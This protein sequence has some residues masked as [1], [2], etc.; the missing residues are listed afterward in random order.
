[1]TI[2]CR[3]VRLIGTVGVVTIAIVILILSTNCQANQTLQVVSDHTRIVDTSTFADD[4]KPGDEVFSVDPAI[5]VGIDYETSK[6][7]LTVEPSKG[8]HRY[9]RVT[10]RD[11]KTGKTTRCGASAALY[12][13]I[14]KLS[15]IRAERVLKP[16]EAQNLWSRYES[17]A[18]TLRI[19]DT[20]NTDAK[21]FR[22][23]LIV[24]PPKTVLLRDFQY[25]FVPSIQPEWFDQF[26]KGCPRE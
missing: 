16:L 22:V 12:K 24:G 25:L 5:I 3:S 1:M 8:Q 4:L 7:K 10:V 9:F 26:T 6:R 17:N 11:L 21:E 2:R 13:A 23:I 20:L 15:S 14:M 18:A 19:R